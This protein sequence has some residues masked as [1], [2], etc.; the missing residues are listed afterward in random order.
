MRAP[1][2]PFTGSACV[3]VNVEADSVRGL[4]ARGRRVTAWGAIPLDAG[5]VQ[6]GA[7]VDGEAVAEATY[8]LLESLGARGGRLLASV[9][10]QRSV[11]R[12]LEFPKMESRLVGEA[13]EREMKRELPVPLDETYIASQAIGGENGRMKVFALGL[14]RDVLDPLVGA[15]GLLGMR[16]H[17]ADIKPLALVRAVARA[18]TLIVDVERGS[19]DV[20]VVQ[21]GVPIT[22]R[23]VGLAG[24]QDDVQDVIGRAAEELARTVKFYRDT[25]GEHEL[26]TDTPLSVTGSLAREVTET[27]QASTGL[28]AA[29]I[30]VPMTC[31][32]GFEPAAYMVNI[33]LALKEV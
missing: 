2:L 29:P 10:G 14:P 32:K 26:P 21:D 16:L 1:S 4:V 17:A 24:A 11:P 25:H 31:P 20:I 28:T 30:S 7:V 27:A 22:I 5:V 23:T 6:N 8:R 3:A 18:N 13:V 19:I 33:G 9:T 12:I 15:F